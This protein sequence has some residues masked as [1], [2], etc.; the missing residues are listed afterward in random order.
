MLAAG[1]DGVKNKY[2]LPEPVERDI[3]KMTEAE[4]EKAG[5]RSLPGSLIEA[6]MLTEKSDLIREALGDH[7]FT[8]FIAS[9]KVEW[10]EF[11]TDVSRWEI[12]K[13]L[14]LL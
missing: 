1:M 14:P 7:I 13:Y 12:E 9:K 2:E 11:R 4:K 5:I 6:L 10:D 3:F 8:N